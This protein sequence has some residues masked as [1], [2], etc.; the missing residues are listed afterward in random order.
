MAAVP[1]TL[2]MWDSF[3][4]RSFNSPPSFKSRITSILEY[5][6]F[7]YHLLMNETYINYI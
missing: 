1:S 5:D 3:P 7:H 4:R 6:A 2:A